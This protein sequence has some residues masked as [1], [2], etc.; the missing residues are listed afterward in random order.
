MIEEK[1]K[2]VEQKDI[3]KVKEPGKHGKEKSNKKV[4]I[5][6]SII[7]I[8]I[9]IAIL[10]TIF[11]LINSK[12]EKMLNGISINGI[13]VSGKDKDEVKEILSEKIEAKKTEDLVV[14]LDAKTEEGAEYK[15]VISFEQLQLNYKLDEAIEKAYNIGRDS[16]I[17]VNN[18]NIV[19]T[20]FAKN[21]IEIPYEYNEE[22]LNK[23]IDTING[24][25]PGAVIESSYDID[26]DKKELVITKGK[27]GLEVDPE[28][29]KQEVENEIKNVESGKKEINLSTKNKE[30]NQINLD[31]IYSEIHTEPQNAYYTQNPFTLYPHVDGIDFAISMEEAKKILEENKEEYIIPLKI[32]HPEITTDKIGSEGFPDLLAEFS[33]NY[34][35]GAKD[36]TTNLR[37][38]SN[39]INNTVVL[40]GETF[41]YNKVVG[42]RTTEAGYK[43]AP[44]YAG[45]KVVN[46]IGGGICQITSTLYN[47]VVLANLD[48]VSRSN[49]QFVPS[50]VKAGRDATVVYGA[51]DFKFKNTRKYPIKIKSTVSGGVARVQIY[52]MKEET[53]YEVKIETKITGS[54]PMKTVYEDDPTLEKGKEKVEQ[55][56]HN[57]TYSE[58]YKVV[59][60][61]GKV[62]SRTLL[63]KDK[64]NQMSTIIKRGTKGV[65]APPVEPEV[66]QEPDVPTNPEIPEKP[67]EPVEP[68]V[69][70]EKPSEGNNIN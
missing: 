11:A 27:E 41:S 58:A 26:E 13:S 36:R 44:S 24:Q 32:T 21:N 68:P 39:K 67:E 43:E 54:I 40:P 25:I 8:I 70:P 10:S 46:D 23:Q 19:K 69:I 60:L 42:K 20:F 3:P 52:G 2:I 6:C 5:I 28:L 38:A 9:V 49:H 16:N 53:E 22:E 45:G 61:N 33:T 15:G 55:K 59:Y 7:A 56:G 57:G 17:F 47:A 31:K 34:N 48:I 63:S 14:K 12:N 29:L 37:L 64:Y 65:E 30:P 51:I 1:E 62:V 4:I 66:P 50:Y 18:F 35:P